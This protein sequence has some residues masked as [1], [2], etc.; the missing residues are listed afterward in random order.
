MLTDL[1]DISREGDPGI[2][3]LAQGRVV[4]GRLVGRF[5]QHMDVELHGPDVRDGQQGGHERGHGVG[6]HPI[7]REDDVQSKVLRNEGEA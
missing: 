5:A 3:P 7:M 4:K 6:G 2:V 1:A